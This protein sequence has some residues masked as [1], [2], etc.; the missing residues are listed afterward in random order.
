MVEEAK[1]VVTFEEGSVESDQERA[2]PQLL[3]ARNAVLGDLDDA[4]M[5]VFTL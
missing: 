1:M 3:G 5:D 2:R 4:H